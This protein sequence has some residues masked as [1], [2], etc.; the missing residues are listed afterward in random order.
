MTD[1]SDLRSDYEMPGFRHYGRF[2]PVSSMGM[3]IYWGDVEG[4]DELIA[5]Y[6]DSTPE[7]AWAINPIMR[8]WATRLATMASMCSAVTGM[9]PQTSLL[10]PPGSGTK[11]ELLCSVSL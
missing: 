6:C 11:V 3:H 5:S 1:E 2:C 7:T 4:A 10:G 8:P 9:L